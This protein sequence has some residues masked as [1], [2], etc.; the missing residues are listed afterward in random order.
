MRA[1]E[2]L[3]RGAG[4]LIGTD[5]VTSNNVMDLTG[6]L[7]I[8]G[9]SQRQMSGGR[10]AMPSMKI[11]E[12]VTVDAARAIG[13][14][15]KLGTLAPGYLADMVMLD[16]SGLHAAPNYSL[17]DTII[18]TCTGRDVDTVMVNGQ[19]VVESGRLLTADEDELVQLAETTGRRLIQ[20]A[21]DQDPE[22]AWLWK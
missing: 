2:L 22:L 11:L 10:A 5:C 3:Q 4:V 12:M 20:R 6:E 17:A 21:V 19:V 14:E 1:W 8:A 9:A 13:M 7:R 16:I 18:Y 15:G